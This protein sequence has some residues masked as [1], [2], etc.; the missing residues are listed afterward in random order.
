M[1]PSRI[2]VMIDSPDC[3]KPIESMWRLGKRCACAG[4]TLSNSGKTCL[5][6]RISFVSGVPKVGAG[7]SF[8][9]G[10]FQFLEGNSLTAGAEQPY[11]RLSLD[12]V[13][14]VS[15]DQVR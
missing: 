8:Q 9:G 15:T 7:T 13:R 3:Q 11:H 1:V 5:K 6:E 4:Q 10:R 14:C 2:Q 12:L